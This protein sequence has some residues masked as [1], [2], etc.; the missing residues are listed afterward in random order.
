MLEG[1]GPGPE[2]VDERG[3]VACELPDLGLGLGREL[4]DGHEQRELP[5]TQG[6]EDLPVVAAGPDL[7]AVGDDPERGDV[8]TATRLLCASP[9][10]YP[11]PRLGLQGPAL[12]RSHL[13][14]S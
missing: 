2:A 12:T 14:P 11:P 9:P 6:V 1:L 8:V 7:L 13:R 10:R 4:V 3:A 5:V